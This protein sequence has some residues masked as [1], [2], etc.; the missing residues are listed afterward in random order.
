MAYSL[1]FEQ[2][3]LLLNLFI[4]AQFSYAPLISMF[5]SRKL[6]NRINHI[7]ERALRLVYKDYTSSFDE[8]LL[9]DNSFSIHYRNLQRLI[10]E[11][12]TVKLGLASEIMKNVFP[13][14]EN[15][16]NLRNETKF[17]SK[18]VHT[19]RYVIETAS[20]VAPRIWSSIPR[21]YKECSS[22]NEFK[23]KIKFWYPENY[24][25]KP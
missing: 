16:Y 6:N 14:I 21:S 24:Q 3:K 7:H 22:A 23:A 1:K 12:F 19:V 10:I 13:I 4:T 17:K 5:H 11:I 15:P 9:K 18:N 25:C 2:R 8:L 20:L